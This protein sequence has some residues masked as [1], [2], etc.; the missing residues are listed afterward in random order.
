MARVIPK[1]HLADE[2]RRVVCDTSG[3]LLKSREGIEWV[4]MLRDEE[5]TM[6]VGQV[7]QG[8]DDP[9]AS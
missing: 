2:R 7:R 3:R 5:R 8:D 1:F 4:G 9:T 6:D